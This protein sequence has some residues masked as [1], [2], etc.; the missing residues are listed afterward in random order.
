MSSIIAV[1]I[2]LIISGMAVAAFLMCISLIRKV[3]SLQFEINELKDAK[4]IKY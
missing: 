4:N 1:T 3:D 2:V